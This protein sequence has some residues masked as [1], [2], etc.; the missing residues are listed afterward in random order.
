MG[1]CT[2]IGWACAA[3]VL[4]CWGCSAPKS[5]S[6]MG[7]MQGSSTT[8]TTAAKD[9]ANPLKPA[10]SSGSGASTPAGDSSTGSASTG[11]SDKAAS[12]GGFKAA[13][14]DPALRKLMEDELQSEPADKRQQLLA[15]WS[16][17]DPAFIRELVENH[18]MAREV[19]ES[20]QG[21]KDTGWDSGKAVKTVSK[22]QPPQMPAFD[23]PTAPKDSV[24]HPRSA[25]ATPTTTATTTATNSATATNTATGPTDDGRRVGCRQPVG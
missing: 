5:F 1:R 10:D 14:I 19:A 13:A 22:D 20:H 2:V 3:G 16:K 6:P 21:G 25:A 12:G 15:D 8:S 23:D 18:R 11:S 7:W 24:L 17:F 9:P 4:C